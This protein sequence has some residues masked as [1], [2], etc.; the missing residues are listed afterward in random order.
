MYTMRNTIEEMYIIMSDKIRF[1]PCN[2]LYLFE[3]FLF[4]VNQQWYSKLLITV[5]SNTVEFFIHMLLTFLEFL[6]AFHVVSLSIVNTHFLE[7]Y[8]NSNITKTHFVIYEILI[9]F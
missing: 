3:K 2:T 4:S 9:E 5:G 1:I 6:L 8:L 7:D